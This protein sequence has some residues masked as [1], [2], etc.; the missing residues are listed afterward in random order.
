M[1]RQWN[2]EFEIVEACFCF[3][4]ELLQPI[5]RAEVVRE[6]IKSCK[7]DLK[8]AERSMN[9][10]HVTD[11]IGE[12]DIDNVRSADLIHSMSKSAVRNWWRR[13]RKS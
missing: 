11:L 10:R 4:D 8:N 1:L 3:R 9:H 12:I 13:I 7:S 2:D 6:W 5:A